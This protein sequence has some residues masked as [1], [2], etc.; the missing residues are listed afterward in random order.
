MSGL[1]RRKPLA[2]GKPP[3]RSGKLRRGTR[4]KRA[5]HKRKA[6]SHARNF[7]AEADAVRNTPC[8]VHRQ[9]A[10]RGGWGDNE[11]MIDEPLPD[12]WAACS[13]TASEAAHVTARGQGGAKGGRFDIVPLC[14]AHHDEA[15]EARTSQ[16]AEFEQRYGLDLRAEADRVAI[17]HASPLGIRGLAVHWARIAGSWPPGAIFEPLDSYEHDALLGW[18]RREMTREAERSPR[19]DGIDV[20]I[21]PDDREG[22]AKHIA[23]MLGGPFADAPKLA[24]EL[25]EA[26]GWPGVQP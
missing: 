25:C 21:R 3:A 23:D 1:K 16:R 9:L 10:I 2:S 5:N 12:G 20:S 17:G 6:A 7:G 15:G 13:P 22:L 26:A 11:W 14:R 4:V 8:L 19:Y 24:R 18:V